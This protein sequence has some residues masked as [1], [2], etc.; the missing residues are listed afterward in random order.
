[1]PVASV[2][3]TYY[4]YGE[5]ARSY[6]ALYV[7]L[8]FATKNR[9]PVLTDVALRERLHQYICGSSRGPKCTCFIFGGVEGPSPPHCESGPD[10]L[11]G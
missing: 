2:R 7:Y 10:Y 4:S 3:G 1:M 5:L 8:V 9:Q 6:S 11:D